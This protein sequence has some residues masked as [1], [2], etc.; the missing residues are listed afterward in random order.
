MLYNQQA[1]QT[2]DVAESQ[3]YQLQN[4]IAS[5]GQKRGG[6]PVN[7]LSGVDDYGSS[8][9]PRSNFN[10]TQG[11]PIT[12]NTQNGFFSPGNQKTGGHMGGGLYPGNNMQNPMNHSRAHSPVIITWR[13]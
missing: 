12:R 13:I 1:H 8:Y 7:A 2:I 3:S 11:A 4:F 6:S 9:G 10:N 5:H